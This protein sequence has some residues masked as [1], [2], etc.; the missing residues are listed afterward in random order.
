M[1]EWE[2]S[3]KDGRTVIIRRATVNDAEVLY[4][5]FNSVVG[6][7]RWLPVLKPNSNVDDW[8]RWIQQTHF[9]REVI[10]KAMIDGEYVGHLS[11]QPE[12]WMASKHVARLGIV[13]MKDFRCIGVGRALM[14]CAE[15]F[16]REMDYEKI[17]LS[18]FEDNMIARR[19]YES[20]GYRF[21][22]IRKKHFKMP[23]DYIDEVL[24]EKLLH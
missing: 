17:I 13:V 23:H 18:T 21:V 22:G 24:M 14:Q 10:L 4:N 12:E 20:M 16:A 5:G 7:R 2:Y 1:R 9:R 19:L 11:L 15:E 8:T 6:E 3:T